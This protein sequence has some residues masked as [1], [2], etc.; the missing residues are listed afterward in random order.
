MVFVIWV[1]EACNM[2]CRYCYEGIE[3]NKNFMSADT[4]ERV[5]TWITEQ[6]NERSAEYAQVRFHGGEPLLN[7]EIVKMIVSELKKHTNI[8][9]SFQLT[10]N[11]YHITEEQMRFLGENIDELS[12]SMD[13]TSSSHNAN[14][15]TVDGSTTFDKVFANAVK[16]KKNAP[17]TTVRMT[18]TPELCGCFAENVIFLIEN[19]FDDIISSVDLFDKSWTDEQLDILEE[20]CG[21]IAEYISGNFKDDEINIGY[22]VYSDV[23]YRTCSG[24]IDGFNIDYHG[25]LFPC[26]YTVGKTQFKCGDIFNGPDPRKTEEFQM[27]YRQPVAPCNGCDA[28]KVCTSIRCKFLN[29][30]LSGDLLT[31]SP[32]MCSLNRRSIQHYLSE[33]N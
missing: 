19:G 22:P 27:L 13:G 6:M 9:Y 23:K 32:L 8:E 7:F 5:I 33:R 16:M 11:A 15:L 12:V 30:V 18:V 10:T 14:R 2:K 31:P 17:Q 24:G 21:R 29:Y 3:K 4:A 1:T 20:Q 28:Y 25:D 26:T